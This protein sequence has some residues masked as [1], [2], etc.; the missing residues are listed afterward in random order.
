MV[1]GSG[2]C[3]LWTKKLER[4]NDCTRGAIFGVDFAQHET[5]KYGRGFSS[6]SSCPIILTSG[7]ATRMVLIEKIE[8]KLDACRILIPVFSVHS[9][10]MCLCISLQ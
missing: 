5:V 8:P 3:K 9:S 1:V 6:I 4:K 10:S 2:D 7:W